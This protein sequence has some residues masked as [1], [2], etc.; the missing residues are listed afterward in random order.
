LIN[1]TQPIPTL[2]ILSAAPFL[3]QI[4]SS[5]SLVTPLTEK[6]LTNQSIYELKDRVTSYVCPKIVLVYKEKQ[7]TPS[8]IPSSEFA[9][10]IK[11]LLMFR[12]LEDNETMSGQTYLEY[13]KFGVALNDDTFEPFRDVTRAE[14]VKMI[15]RS[16][17]CRYTFLGIDS[18]F[19]DV[20]RDRWYA[21]YITFAVQK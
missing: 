18:G 21:E 4:L 8:D 6:T 5:Q 17:S 14:Y 15:I 19:P 16:L 13:K 11:S 7:L 2:P 10:D 12:G 9:D 3:T 1:F 20:E